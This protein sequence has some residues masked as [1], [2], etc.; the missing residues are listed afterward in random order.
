MTIINKNMANK[1]RNINNLLVVCIYAIGVISCSQIDKKQENEYVFKNIILEDGSNEI[2]MMID[3]LRQGLWIEV[4]KKGVILNTCYYVDSKLRGPY[5]MYYEDGVPKFEAYFKDGEFIGRRV[6]YYP[7]GHI[8]DEGY[9]K[10]GKQDS[11]WTNY[12]EDGRIDKKVRFKDGKQVEV[13]ID[14]KLIP[15]PPM[16][17]AKRSL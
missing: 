9:F 16:P 8:M 17:P 1:L 12:M 2:G 5:N 14:N 15:L 6:T 4:S 10:D 7:N 13:I 3:T 11:I